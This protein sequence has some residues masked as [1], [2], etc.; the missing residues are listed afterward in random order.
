MLQ[1][2]HAQSLAVIYVNVSFLNIYEGTPEPSECTGDVCKLPSQ[3]LP[4]LEVVKVLDEW[5][6]HNQ[7]F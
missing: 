1:S 6:V 2:E 7:N 5:E 3:P 4:E